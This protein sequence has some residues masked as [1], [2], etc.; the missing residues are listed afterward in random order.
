M[1]SF[2]VDEKD[3]FL[4]KMD[5]WNSEKESITSET[6]CNGN[7]SLG[8]L[9]Y[10]SESA[11]TITNSTKFPACMSSSEKFLRIHCSYNRKQSDTV[12]GGWEVTT[13]DTPSWQAAHRDEDKQLIKTPCCLEDHQGELYIIAICS[14]P[15]LP[16]GEAPCH[17]WEKE[18]E[19][20]KPKLLLLP[21]CVTPYTSVHAS[22]YIYIH[23]HTYIYFQ[24]WPLVS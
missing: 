16:R 13:T 12:P 20:S 7:R 3:M 17:L 18:K 14:H 2:K 8:Y 1:E 24:I 5:V 10:S 22:V 4:N 6:L 9:R 21:K 19:K 11:V 15:E 23:T